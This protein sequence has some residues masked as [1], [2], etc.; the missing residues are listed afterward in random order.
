MNSNPQRPNAA[1]GCGRGK[2]FG[3]GDLWSAD[4]ETRIRAEL[5]ALTRPV[6]EHELATTTDD[7]RARLIGQEL[8][9]R[10]RAA[11]SAVRNYGR[12]GAP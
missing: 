3:L 6:L 10:D 8:A 2:R 11:K 5:S 7:N 9:W 1:G 12:L 4:P